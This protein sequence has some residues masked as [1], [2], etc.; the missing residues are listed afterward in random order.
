MIRPFM[1]SCPCAFKERSS[2]FFSIFRQYTDPRVLAIGCIAYANGI[3][4]LLTGSTLNVW[5]KSYSFNFTSIGL[6]GLLHLPYAFKFLWAPILDHVPLPVLKKYL[7]QRRSWLCLVQVTAIVGLLG[8]SFLDPVQDLY[9]FVSF[10][11]LTTF[12]A[13]SQHVLLLTYQIETL[14]SRD[15]GVG[16]GMSVFAYRMA[17]LTGSSGALQLVAFFT[18]Q[19]VYFILTLLMFIGLIA[20]LIMREPDRFA[21]EHN[22]SFTKKGEWIRYALID[23][24]KDFMTKQGWI[25]ILIFMLIYKLPDNLLVKMQPLFLLDLGFTYTEISM[26]AKFFGLGTLVLGGFVG[27]YWIRLYG[28][29]RTLFWG[30]LA[31]GISCSLFL[32]QAQLGAY[33][34]F[35]YIA[36]GIE[37]FFGGVSLTAFFSYQLTC[38]SVAFAATQLAILTSLDTLGR[39]LLQPFVGVFIDHFGWVPYLILVIL[40]SIPGIVWVYY[41]PYSRP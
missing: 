35:L 10:G 20:V 32:I 26:V 1:F 28:Y 29:K 16:E 13:A 5:L 12:S 2:I 6:F 38:S 18:W 41:I 21:L 14:H 34:P 30:G 17:I 25:A 9:T 11:F 19:E 33:L 27:G 31:Y 39:T 40:L 24:F 8:M 22:H 23:P 15:W 3:P 7:G 4:L 37:H 36:I